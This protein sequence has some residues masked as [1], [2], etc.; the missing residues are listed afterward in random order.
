MT[1]LIADERER[2]ALAFL[3][4]GTP[5]PGTERFAR[6]CRALLKTLGE[7]SPFYRTLYYEMEGDRALDWSLPHPSQAMVEVDGQRAFFANTLVQRLV[8][9]TQ[10][11]HAPF[12]ARFSLNDRIQM[13]QL[14]GLTVEVFI[15]LPFVT[16]ALFRSIA[17]SA[18]IPQVPGHPNQPLWLD[19]GQL[20]FQPNR[21]VAF[22]LKE[23]GWSLERL[24]A[25]PDTAQDF[26]QLLQLLGTPVADERKTT[27]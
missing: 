10:W 16:T 11:K 23:S 9:N 25:I 26:Q 5:E 17:A 4:L 22:M 2:D 27:C 20:A 12:L 8:Q 1:L 13:A 14:L 15:T 21:L 24:R 18:R 19:Q 3:R 6:R 7:D